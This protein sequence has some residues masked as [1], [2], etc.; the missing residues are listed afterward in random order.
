MQL[1][2]TEIDIYELATA[3]NG[4]FLDE[5]DLFCIYTDYMDIDFALEALESHLATLRT[6]CRGKTR[7]IEAIDAII[8]LIPEPPTLDYNIKDIHES[9]VAKH[10]RIK[11]NYLKLTN[12]PKRKKS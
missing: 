2:S 7:L 12:Q 3:D 10:E 4:W 6:E 5:N 9:N 11:Q 1:T 8:A